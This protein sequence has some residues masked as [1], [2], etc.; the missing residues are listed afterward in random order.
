MKKNYWK[1]IVSM[2]CAIIMTLSMSIT[3]LAAE[4]TK[5]TTSP[6]QYQITVG[7]TT[8]TLKE[9]QKAVFGMDTLTDSST[10]NGQ[11]STFASSQIVTG[12]AGTLTVWGNGAYFYWNIAM[13]IPATSFMG[14]VT[15]SD[16]TSGLS[17]GTAIAIGFSGKCATRGLSGHTYSGSI[18]GTA[19]FGTVAV[20]V[21]G[22]NRVTWKA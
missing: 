12:N 3:A 4:P 6:N 16:V 9:G 2:T 10:T 21:T 20:A 19:Y 7:D 14:A 22:P 8:V 15:L 18:S 13:T 17:C 5:Q 1:K 11:I